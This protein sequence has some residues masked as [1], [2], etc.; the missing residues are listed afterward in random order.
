[1]GDDGCDD[2][3]RIIRDRIGNYECISDLL[4]NLINLL[5]PQRNKKNVKING[6]LSWLITFRAS[7]M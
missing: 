6:Q 1:M 5:E 3:L 2:F 7:K 4:L